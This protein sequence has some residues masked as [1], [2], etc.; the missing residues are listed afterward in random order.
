MELH[1][2]KVGVQFRLSF[3]ASLKWNVNRLGLVSVSSDNLPLLALYLLYEM[4][5]DNVDHECTH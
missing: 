4:R 2:G 3:E 5:V 1:K